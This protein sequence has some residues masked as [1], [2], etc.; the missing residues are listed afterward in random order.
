MWSDLDLS[1]I[2]F[3]VATSLLRAFPGMEQVTPIWLIEDAATLL[4]PNLAKPQI[5]ANET[6]SGDANC[7]GAC[8]KRSLS[9]FAHAFRLDFA[10]F[11]SGF[12]L[13]V[14]AK[15]C[16]KR[17]LRTLLSPCVPLCVFWLVRRTAFLLL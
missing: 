9:S 1:G 8:T 11:L 13:S 5:L 12:D 17:F 7:A 10:T 16:R 2:L 6:L 15:F 3:H 14:L 4:G